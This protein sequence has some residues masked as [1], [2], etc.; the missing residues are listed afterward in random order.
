MGQEEFDA[1]IKKLQKGKKGTLKR[2]RKKKGTL[3]RV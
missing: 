3:K 1:L 2:E